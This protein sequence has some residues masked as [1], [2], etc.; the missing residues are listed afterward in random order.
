VKT[1]T[2]ITGV[3]TLLVGSLTYLITYFLGILF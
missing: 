3:K 2:F 1:E